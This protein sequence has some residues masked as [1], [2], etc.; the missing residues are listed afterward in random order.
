MSVL[1]R[2]VEAAQHY[3]ADRGLDGWLL[4]DF[5]QN[6]PVFWQ[7]IGER[8]FTTRRAYLLVTPEQTPQ[9]LLHYVDANRLTDLGF[10]V[11]VYRNLDEQIAGLTQLIGG[12]RRVAMEYSPMGALPVA[13]RVDGGTLDLVRSL[14]VEI[15]PSADLL[16]YVVAR[17]G[18]EQ[19]SSHRRAVAKLTQILQELFDHLRREIPR[20]ITEYEA[21]QFLLQR[22]GEEALV[23]ESGPIVAVNAHSG[24]P[25]YEPGP[26]GSSPIRLGDW[27][28]VDWWAKENTPGA[29]YADMTWVAYAGS[30]VPADCRRVFDVV[31]S[32]RDV[33]VGFLEDAFAGGRV[34]QGW[35]VD[36]MARQVIADAG[37]GAFFTHRLGHSI[38]EQDHGNGVNLDSFETRD[39]RS[40]IPGAAFSVEPG[41]YLPEFGVRLE[42][43]VYQSANGPEITTPV[44]REVVLLG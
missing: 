3:L 34:V 9:F 17:W 20:G 21:C 23:T 37:Y 42:I 15:I 18:E 16:Q 10:P 13:S 8:R 12:A 24:D 7:F 22:F 14:N 2:H 31:R 1:T 32:A 39:T 44:Q 6:N 4:V 27:I 26:E 33:A 29:V 5:Q 35:E 40:V 11:H 43:N 19:L 36:Q 28:L 41:I 30:T 25:H 38:G